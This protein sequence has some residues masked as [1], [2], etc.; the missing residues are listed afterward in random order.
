MNDIT[1]TA[2]IVISFLYGYVIGESKREI[3][4]FYDEWFNNRKEDEV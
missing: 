2:I 3:K 4:Q 1:L